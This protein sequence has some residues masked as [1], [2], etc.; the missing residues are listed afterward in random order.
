M[1]YVLK[2]EL[3][4]SE[5]EVEVRA[6]GLNFRDVLIVLDQY[7]GPRTEPGTDCAGVVRRVGGNVRHLSRFAP[8]FGTAFGC[9]AAYARTDARMQVAKP[10][11]LSFEGA[12]TLIST[13]CTVHVGFERISLHGRRRLLLHAAAGGVGLTA[14]EYAQWLC[15][16]ALCTAGAPHK[17]RLLRRQGVA[18]MAS[19]RDATA[20]TLGAQRYLCGLRL[21]A[22]LNSLSADFISA[23]CALLGERGRF[24]EIGKRGIWSQ[25]RA[26]AIG[27]LA[28]DHLDM[29]SEVPMNTEWFQR[30]VLR[31]LAQRASADVVHSLPVYEFDIVHRVQD[32]FRFLANGKNTVP[33][34]VQVQKGTTVVSSL[35]PRSISSPPAPSSGGRRHP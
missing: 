32:A 12:T 26:G 24:E 15:A 2:V 7:P 3:L 9:L 11:A 27:L 10:A 4:S 13:W 23:A 14:L 35:P 20:S 19:S 22:V 29:A 21:H 31:V 18:L 28:Y 5:V 30:S 17:H 8:S 16:P 25:G 34:F 33:N 1:S 6:V